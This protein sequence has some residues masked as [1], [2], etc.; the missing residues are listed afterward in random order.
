MAVTR[1]TNACKRMTPWPRLVAAA[2]FPHTSFFLFS[3]SLP[4]GAIPEDHRKAVHVMACAIDDHLSL[5]FRH[6]VTM[7]SPTLKPVPVSGKEGAS[8]ASGL[9]SVVRKSALLNVV[10]VLTSFPVLISEGGPNA[11]VPILKIMAGISVVIWTTTFALFSFV[12]LA[13]IFWKPVTIMKRLDPPHSANGAG[14]ADR[15]LDGT[16]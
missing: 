14:V 10:I 8:P 3:E 4:V 2:G 12:S 11:L 6:G 9:R 13:R 5:S 7:N 15:W 16:V 1:K